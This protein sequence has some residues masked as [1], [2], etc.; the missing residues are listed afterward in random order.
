MLTKSDLVDAE[1]LEVVRL[2]VEDF[3]RGSFLDP[4]KSLIIP[5][6]SRTGAGIEQLKSALLKAA[7]E[8]P[9][10]DSAALP[11]LPIDRVFSMKGFGTVVTGTLVSGTIH[12]EDELE[13]FPYGTRVRVRGVQVHGNPAEQATAGERTALNL[14]GAGKEELARGAVLAQAQTFS[15]TRVVD[16]SLSLLNLS[17]TLKDRARVHLHA[18][19]FETVAEI[20]L[21]GRKQI[22][23]GE[24]AFAQLRLAEP[25]LFLPGDRFIIRQFSPVVTIGGGAVLDAAPLPRRRKG[26]DMTH[27]LRNHA[28]WFVRGNLA[29]S[30][31]ATDRSGI[32]A[33]SIH[34]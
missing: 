29:R 30:Y 17:K 13:L 4:A 28:Q 22:V 6:S 2:E 23:P 15:A 31:R 5:V 21:H 8:V 14:T 1:T 16:V 34:G 10:R 27:F 33:A 11:R 9:T 32:V 12:K 7:A 3:L 26:Q 24:T 19:T 25:T 18:Y 20:V